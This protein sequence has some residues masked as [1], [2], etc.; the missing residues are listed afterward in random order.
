MIGPELLT[1]V[2]IDLLLHLEYIGRWHNSDA[3]CGWY[4]RPA[5]IITEVGLHLLTDMLLLE[6][7]VT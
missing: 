5:H 3:R 4:L 6:N 1:V 7:Y 2:H